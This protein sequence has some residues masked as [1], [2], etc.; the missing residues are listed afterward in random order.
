MITEHRRRCFG[1]IIELR[2]VVE[3]NCYLIHTLRHKEYANQRGIIKIRW[4]IESYNRL[5][6]NLSEVEIHPASMSSS[7]SSNCE[8]SDGIGGSMHMQD[9]FLYTA[10]RKK[11]GK[12]P[13][14]ECRHSI[15]ITCR[16]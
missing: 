16:G 11:Q 1:S 3:L 9:N 14:T 5:L 8:L 4:V 7:M 10:A 6:V 15:P 2:A 12:S 13:P